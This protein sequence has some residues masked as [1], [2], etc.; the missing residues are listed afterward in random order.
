MTLYMVVC[1]SFEPEVV[2]NLFS[3]STSVGKSVIA[4][5]IYRGYV[6]SFGGS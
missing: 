6:V 1:F 3:I 2:S 5:S 4:Q